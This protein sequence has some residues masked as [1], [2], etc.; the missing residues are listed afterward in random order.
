MAASADAQ[1]YCTAIKQQVIPK[2][3]SM[4]QYSVGNMSVASS[5]A[6]QPIDEVRMLVKWVLAPQLRDL[7]ESGGPG[8]SEIIVL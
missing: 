8:A 3:V 5:A 1:W 2:K 6:L 4:L 7:F